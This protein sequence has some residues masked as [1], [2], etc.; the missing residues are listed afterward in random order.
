MIKKTIVPPFT[1][2][3]Y[4]KRNQKKKEEKHKE[5][6]R[7]VVGGKSRMIRKRLPDSWG[8]RPWNDAE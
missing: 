3:M 8:D 6:K 1:K 4:E 5:A 7:S 2:E